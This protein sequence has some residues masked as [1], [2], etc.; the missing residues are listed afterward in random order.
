MGAMVHM[1]VAISCEKLEACHMGMLWVP[2]SYQ[3]KQMGRAN[4]PNLVDT[5]HTTHTCMHT[6]STIGV[7]RRGV[8]GAGAPLL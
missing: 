8:P 5:H 1:Q 7:G 6:H 2:Y 3:Q 4:H